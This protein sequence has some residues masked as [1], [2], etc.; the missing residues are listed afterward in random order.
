[1]RGSGSIWTARAE[2]KE[3]LPKVSAGSGMWVGLSAGY[4]AVVPAGWRAGWG[5]W[6]ES[7]SEFA[8]WISCSFSINPGRPLSGSLWIQLACDQMVGLGSLMLAR[9]RHLP[10]L[11]PCSGAGR[12]GVSV[13]LLLSQSVS[14]SFSPLTTAPPHPEERIWLNNAHSHCYAHYLLF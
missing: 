7:C 12:S 6:E 2:P 4:S 9:N 14:Y 5:G 11:W 3:V 13:S 8:L 10:I 1:M